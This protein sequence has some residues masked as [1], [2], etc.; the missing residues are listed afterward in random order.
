MTLHTAAV[1]FIG[2]VQ[3]IQ[4]LH[5]RLDSTANDCICSPIRFATPHGEVVSINKR[6]WIS[7]R[8]TPSPLFCRGVAVTVP[9][10]DRKRATEK[11]LP[12]PQKQG[13]TC[14]LS[15]TFCRRMLKVRV[16]RPLPK[17]LDGE[18]LR[19]LFEQCPSSV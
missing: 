1:R 19:N 6:L 10:S 12:D 14:T 13:A 7:P 9:F 17:R 5:G 8:T 4:F 3:N 2:V 16:H 15:Y 18:C 11:A